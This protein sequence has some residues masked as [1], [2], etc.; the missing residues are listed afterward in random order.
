VPS[1]STFWPAEISFSEAEKAS[2][3]KTL[4]PK[5]GGRTPEAEIELLDLIGDRIRVYLLFKRE[6]DTRAEPREMRREILAVHRSAKALRA[7]IKAL[8]SHSRAALIARAAGG[9]RRFKDNI[10]PFNESG[11]VDGGQRIHHLVHAIELSVL[12]AGRTLKDI[13]KSSSGPKGNPALVTLVKA[14]A[15]IFENE[16]GHRFSRTYKLGGREFVEVI[17]AKAEPQATR[18]Q[19]DEAMKVA[20]HPASNKSLSR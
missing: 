5:T 7:A 2:I 1:G 3:L 14:L 8:N 11:F 4:P 20:I 12:W 18:S 10:T 15:P 16:T 17:A 13:P 19:I 6:N 9:R